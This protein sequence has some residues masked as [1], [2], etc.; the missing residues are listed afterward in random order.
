MSTE[1]ALLS[2]QPFLPFKVMVCLSPL[3]FFS[4]T[5]QARPTQQE[6]TQSR[7]FFTEPGCASSPCQAHQPSHLAQGPLCWAWAWAQ[8]GLGDTCVRMRLAEQAVSSE[9]G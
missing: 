6:E 4:H 1:P 8:T 2:P 5:S 3:P 9:V 7:V